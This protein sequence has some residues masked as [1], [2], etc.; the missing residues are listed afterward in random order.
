[1]GVALKLHRHTL[2]L[3][4]CV[5]TIMACSTTQSQ[6]SVG[7]NAPVAGPPKRITAIV[8]SEHPTLISKFE[9]A[10]EGAEAIE[11]SVASGLTVTD[12][13]GKLIPVL[14]ESVPSIENGTWSL[15]P[16]G[17]METTW[18]LRKNTFWH[19]GTPFTANDLLFT[20]RV[21]EESSI[22][23]FRQD[24]GELIEGIDA[25]DASTLV[26]RWTSPF[27]N[28]DKLFSNDLE[29]T[30][31]HFPLPKHLLERHWIES[32]D[33]FTDLSYWSDDFVGTGPFKLKEWSR[34]ERA[35]LVANDQFILGRPTID[36][37]EVRFVKDS[38]TAIA[39]LLSG[40][41]D[42]TLGRGISIEQ[43]AE[44][45]ARWQQGHI[46]NVGLRSRFALYPQFINPSPALIGNL[47][48]RKALMHAI[49][50][51]TMADT[52]QSGLVPVAH[53]FMGTDNPMYPQIEPRIVKYEFD[54]RKASQMIEA[55]GVTRGSDGMFAQG[56]QR[57]SLE[58][59]TT[60]GDLY[61]KILAA[62]RDY[63]Q[64]VG[65][66][67]EA[68]SVP[69]QRQRD[70]EYRATRP[71]F[72]LTRRG[73]N[74]S[75]MIGFVGRQTPLPETRFIGSNVPRYQNADFDALVDRYFVTVPI[76]ARTQVAGEIMHHISDQL[77]M[78]H[79]MYDSEPALIS[80]RIIN[81]HGRGSESTQTWNVHQW[82][83][84]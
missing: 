52:L 18:R 37:L 69:L 22:P 71:G 82:N 9:R 32:K 41:A 79:I 46:D 75:Q 38:S 43:A 39:N 2:A 81:A 48:F 63:W 25:P 64:G 58:M 4:A 40:A 76:P 61:D 67:A 65:V 15:L 19:D 70:L 7:S 51:Q 13:T 53:T 17:R 60:P 78:M 5:L 59:R 27:I 68:V 28:A 35:I 72:E 33:G 73:T 34:G 42:M 54:P 29:G 66:G 80:N 45:G 24:G 1:M 23:N 56:G 57:L 10:L 62:V 84:K 49:D 26:V 50:R 8:I 16:G 12:H 55:I 36:E 77:N 44:V 30:G 11:A 20:A 14:A 31:I 21:G 3:A 74:L 83:V 47:Q 6:S